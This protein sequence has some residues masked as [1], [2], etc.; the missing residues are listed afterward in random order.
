MSDHDK[1]LFSAQKVSALTSGPSTKYFLCRLT[2]QVARKMVD[3][4]NRAFA[5]LGL[6][7][8]QLVAL[9]TLAFS[10]NLTITDFAERLRIRKSTAV[11]MVKRLEAL[12]LV[13]KKAHPSDGRS[14]ILEITD[15]TRDLLPEIQKKA[16]ELEESLEA[17][18]GAS[19]LRKAVDDLTMLL[20]AKF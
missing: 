12:G 16:I 6:T 9:G 4:Y 17:Q 15:K 5:P 13:V 19:A 7:A 2:T 18:I 1:E 14:T 20:N 3:H 8:R 10:E 11:T